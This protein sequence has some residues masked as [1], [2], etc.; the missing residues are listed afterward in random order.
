MNKTNDKIVVAVAWPYV[1]GDLHVGHVA[2]YLLPAD[3]CARFN[4]LM[5][6]DVLMVSGSDCFGTPIT[7]E[8]DKRNTTPEKI[9]EE[10][11]AHDLELFKNLGLTYSLYTKTDT[12]NHR[13]ITQEFLLSFW[14]KGL[15][16]VKTQQ[17]YFDPIESKFLP[18]RYVEGKCP[19]CGFEGARSDQCDN[20]GK[21]LEQN[22]IEPYSKTTK[23]KVI[24]KETEHLFIQWDKLQEKIESYVLKSSPNWKEWVAKETKN[25]LDGGL[26]ER[27]VTRDIDWGV[28]IPDEIVSK[29]PDFKNKRIYVWF[30]AVIGY[31][32]A[33]VEWAQ[34][35]NT[36]WKPFWYGD[37]DHYYFMGKD[38]LVFH[39]IFWPGQLM[40]FDEK[41]ALPTFPVI[42]QYLNLAGQKFS[43]SRG[44]T[45]DTARFIEK[46][47]ADALR[48]YLASIMPE[49]H[50]SNFTWEDFLQKNNDLLVAQIGN[51]V[52]RTL[53]IYKGHQGKD[54]LLSDDVLKQI[55]KSLTSVNEHL[56]KCE[57][58]LYI[59]DVLQFASFA[60]QYFNEI[61]VWEL[62]KNNP[63]TFAKQ[64]GNFIAMTAFLILIM[65][66]VT[67]F[68]VEKYFKM[69]GLEKPSV[70]PNVEELESFLKST[71]EKITTESVEILFAKRTPEEIESF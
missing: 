35:N 23:N 62:K 53:S 5:G 41:L 57:F 45:I 59:E 36:D 66:P 56:Q 46:F 71:A 26:H 29:H 10:Y 50:D 6:R 42:N 38:N 34:I 31:Y 54:I 27:A 44:V 28:E 13:K 32:S 21:L 58:K 37:V 25:W 30:D 52:N 7:V 64:Y 9:V 63:E 12:L 48:F 39:T 22:L 40:T 3:M 14:N 67:P 20:C 8:A 60:N 17:Q 4:R 24:L 69:V 49:T 1:N 16:T 33:S 11:H 55:K 70:W 15:L 61:K 68:A 47:G 43:K 18:D 2:G 65:E 19:H 51:Y